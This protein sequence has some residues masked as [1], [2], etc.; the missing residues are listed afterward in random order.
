MP[1]TGAWTGSLAATVFDIKRKYAFISIIFGVLV[2]GVIVTCLSLLGWLGAVIAGTC[3]ILLV[4]F[5]L[6]RL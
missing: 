2:A 5:G 3:L 4:V 1:V 6:W